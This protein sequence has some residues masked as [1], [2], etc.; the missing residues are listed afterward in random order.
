MKGLTLTQQE[1]GRTRT[2]NLVLEGCMGVAEAASVLGIS[3]RHA[4]RILAAYR[5]GGVAALAH[6]NRGRRPPNAA[7]VEVRHRVTV[8]ARTRYQGLNHTHLTEMLAEREG[9]TLEVVP[10]IWTGG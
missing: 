1:Q 8:L 7:S 10:E 4:W 5:R 2:L 9:V 6:G 3:E